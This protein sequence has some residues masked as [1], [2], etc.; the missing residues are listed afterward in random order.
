[1]EITKK[2]EKIPPREFKC[3]LCGKEGINVVTLT[4]PFTT[5]RLVLCPLCSEYGADV[6][7]I[8]FLGGEDD[9]S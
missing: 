4:L 3:M 2:V 8:T 6:L 7:W 9:G 5:V 1:M